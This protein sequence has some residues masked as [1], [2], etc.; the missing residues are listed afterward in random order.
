M[1]NHSAIFLD[2][3]GVIIKDSHLLTNRKNIQILKEAPEALLKFKKA[4]YLLVVVS[5]QTVVA[6]GLTTERDVVRI[7][8]HINHLLFKIN[9]VKI[10][11]FYFND[12]V[13]QFFESGNEK[14]LARCLRLLIQDE[15]LRKQQAEN[16]FKFVE[17]Y[18]WDHHQHKYFQLL[19]RLTTNRT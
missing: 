10:D 9:G 8:N 19:D 13:I 11:K 7:N 2:R 6:R 12:S 18:S 4:G 5:N 17:K 1:N 14:D 16:A 15:S 3:D